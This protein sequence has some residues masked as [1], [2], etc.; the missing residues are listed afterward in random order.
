MTDEIEAAAEQA[1]RATQD[2]PMAELLTRLLT[3]QRDLRARLEQL[4][5]SVR[6]PSPTII[7]DVLFPP[8]KT[9]I[10]DPAYPEKKTVVGQWYD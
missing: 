10:D 8:F 2:A 9:T 4:A 1:R 7:V 3:E 6:S 5:Q